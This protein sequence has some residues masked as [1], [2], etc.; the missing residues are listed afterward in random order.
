MRDKGCGA[1]ER[2]GGAV[3]MPQGLPCPLQLCPGSTSAPT[4]QWLSFDSRAVRSCGFGPS[5]GVAGRL[6]RPVAVAGVCVHAVSGG[7]FALL[8]EDIQV[9]FVISSGVQV[10]TNS[11]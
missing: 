3:A 7:V 6:D 11:G 8:S 2:Q 1:A 5:E 4:K 9:C 10:F